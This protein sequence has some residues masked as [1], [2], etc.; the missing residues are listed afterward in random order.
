MQIGH[1]GV[2][3]VVPIFQVSLSD[4]DQR[5]AI[6]DIVKRKLQ[7]AA[8]HSDLICL[9]GS[10]EFSKSVATLA[11]AGSHLIIAIDRAAESGKITTGLYNAPLK[12][13]L[14]KGS[15]TKTASLDAIARHHGDAMG[16]GH[17]TMDGATNGQWW[18][19]D[20]NHVRSISTPDVGDAVL[21]DYELH[22]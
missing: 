12:R 6:H 4:K 18:R 3:G 2:G 21:A 9:C 22:R 10:H 5:V 11:P 13:G 17:F 20:D 19:V 8:A 14:F 1:D 15:S 16:N 7:E